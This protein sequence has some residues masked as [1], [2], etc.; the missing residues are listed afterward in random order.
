MSARTPATAAILPPAPAMAAP[1]PDGRDLSSVHELVGD[2]VRVRQQTLF[3]QIQAFIDR[4][5]DDPSLTPEMIADAH[6][7]STRTLQRLFQAHGSA[8]AKWIRFQRL[9][10]CRRDLANPLL[11]EQLIQAIA[12]RWGFSTPA[13]FTRVFRATYGLNPQDYRRGVSG[14]GAASMPSIH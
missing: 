1:E 4:R 6:H 9:E 7:I 13:H 5:L 3:Q 8:V 10:R 14:A 2:R 12:A 11:S